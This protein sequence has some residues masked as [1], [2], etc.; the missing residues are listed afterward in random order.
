MLSLLK[1][2]SVGSWPLAYAK[3]RAVLNDCDK[4]RV[5]QWEAFVQKV[6]MPRIICR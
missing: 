5:E 2:E 3:D 6:Q 1:L 4:R